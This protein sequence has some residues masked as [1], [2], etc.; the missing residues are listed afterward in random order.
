MRHRYSVSWCYIF[1]QRIITNKKLNLL[2]AL[3]MN[4]LAVNKSKTMCDPGG[5]K[6]ILLFYLSSHVQLNFFVA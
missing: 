4:K 6:D 5:M 3:T 1:Y 2:V